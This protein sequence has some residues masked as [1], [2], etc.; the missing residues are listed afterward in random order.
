MQQSITNNEHRIIIQ[1]YFSSDMFSFV[2]YQDAFFDDINKIGLSR[3]TF[4]HT[5]HYHEH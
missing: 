1:K 2:R 4:E 5:T 3:H